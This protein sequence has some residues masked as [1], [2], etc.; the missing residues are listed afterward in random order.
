LE[1]VVRKIVDVRA[2]DGVPVVDEHCNDSD[3]E[4]DEAENRFLANPVEEEDG[5]TR[6]SP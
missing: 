3:D 6:T 4:V 5:L 1:E 2:D